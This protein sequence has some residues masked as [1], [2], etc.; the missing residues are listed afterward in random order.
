MK[1][2]QIMR[3]LYKIFIVCFSETGQSIAVGLKDLR[4]ASPHNDGS[5]E[6]PRKLGRQQRDKNLVERKKEG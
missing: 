1:L 6:R 3:N 4:R 5:G 2:A